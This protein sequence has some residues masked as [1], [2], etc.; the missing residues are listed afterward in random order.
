M[1]TV[2]FPGL[3]QRAPGPCATG[4]LPTPTSALVPVMRPAP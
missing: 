4:R 1:A 3:G 2:L